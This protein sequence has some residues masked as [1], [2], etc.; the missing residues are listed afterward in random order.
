MDKR[1]LRELVCDYLLPEVARAY[2]VSL[3][4]VLCIVTD[5]NGRNPGAFF[6]KGDLKVLAIDRKFIERATREEAEMVIAHELLE[7]KNSKLGPF[8]HFTALREE[9]RL[10]GDIAKDLRESAILRKNNPDI[11]VRKAV[12]NILNE[13]KRGNYKRLGMVRYR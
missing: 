11:D 13:A 10:F 6:R 5:L 3:D 1:I 4:G 2:N 8:A 9:K 7:Y 12:F